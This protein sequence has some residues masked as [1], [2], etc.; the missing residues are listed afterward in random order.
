MMHI[1]D[2]QSDA[3]RV[4]RLMDVVARQAARIRTMADALVAAAEK[5]TPDARA[6]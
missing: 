6:L 3:E 2:Y 1:A 5:E 4:L